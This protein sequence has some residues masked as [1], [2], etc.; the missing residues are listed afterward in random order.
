MSASLLEKA[1]SEVLGRLARYKNMNP[2]LA[3]EIVSDKHFMLTVA[4]ETNIEKTEEKIESKFIDIANQLQKEEEKFKERLKQKDEEIN[5]LKES[6][7]VREKKSEQ[8]TK[9]MQDQLQALE[10][11]LNK[12]DNDRKKVDDEK[13]TKEDELENVKE[14]FKRFRKQLIKWL[15]FGGSF[16]VISLCLWLRPFGMK[17]TTLDTN[18]NRTI[19]EIALQLLL[20]FILLNIPLKK[21]W[22]VWLIG[23]GIPLLISILSFFL[24]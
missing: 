18:K 15:V 7:I 21:H 2:E 19:I 16:T 8:E 4:T 24:H 1:Y 12:V 14:E 5:K 13:K 22:K 3:L 20:L 23:A 11:R 17:W 9:R 6:L 10:S